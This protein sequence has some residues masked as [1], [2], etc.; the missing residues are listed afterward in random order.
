MPNLCGVCYLIRC[1]GKHLLRFSRSLPP[2]L[3]FNGDR[4]M[5][6]KTVAVKLFE[7]AGLADWKRA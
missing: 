5:K 4:M 3:N 7:V 6:G 1:A 2:L